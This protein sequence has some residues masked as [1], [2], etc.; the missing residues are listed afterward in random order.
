MWQKIIFFRKQPHRIIRWHVIK[1]FENLT[2]KKFSNFFFEILK[3]S[4]ANDQ[5]CFLLDQNFCH[6]YI[7]YIFNCT[8]SLL[9]RTCESALLA[10][11]SDHSSPPAFNRWKIYKVQQIYRCVAPSQENLLIWWARRPPLHPFPILLSFS[12]LLI[13][14]GHFLPRRFFYEGCLGYQLNNWYY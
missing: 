10:P 3:R 7:D 13:S 4:L 11:T 9:W 2:E 12:L 14:F 1:I 6:S 8:F 5:E